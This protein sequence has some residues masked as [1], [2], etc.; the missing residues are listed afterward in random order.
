VKIDD[1]TLTLFEWPGIPTTRYGNFTGQVSGTSQLGLLRIR[2][3]DGV[4][5]N[6]F[7]GAASRPATIDARSLI[8]VLKPVLMGSD[9]L[10]R[11]LLHRAMS[12]KL[13]ATTWRALGAVDVALWDLA[14][15]VAGLPVNRL[16]GSARQT[17]AAYASSS[18]LP[19][20]DA[21]VEEAQRYRDAG[22]AG[23]KIHPPGGWRADIALCRAVRDGVGPDFALMLDPAWSYGYPEAVRVGAVLDELDFHWYEDPLAPDDIYNYTKLRSQVRVP[24]LATERA[25]GGLTGYAPWILA[26]ATDF[27]RGDVAVKGGITGCIKA[28][29]LAEAFHLNFEIHHGGNSLNNLANLHVALAIANCEMFEVLLPDATQKYGLRTEPE[30]DGSGELQCPTGPGLGADIDLELVRRHTVGELS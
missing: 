10:D 8:D 22:W 12:A 7:L 6:A 29:H 5:G 1:V 16:L 13:R 4:E 28:A 20:R 9:P 14:G 26:Q 18:I 27:L 30:V 3:D 24:I 17:I 15:K 19:S 25:P 11:E 2:V 21:Y 23:Y